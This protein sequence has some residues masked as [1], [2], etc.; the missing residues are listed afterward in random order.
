MPA[1]LSVGWWGE[2]PLG[3]HLKNFLVLPRV[4]ATLHFGDEPVA[5]EDR[6]QLAAELH[7]EVA[8]RFRPFVETSEVER[9]LRLRGEDPESLPAVLRKAPDRFN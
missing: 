2:M 3:E 1:H 8:R 9:L 7:R 6:K 5:A 4:D